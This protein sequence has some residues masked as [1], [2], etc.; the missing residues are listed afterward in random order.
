[1]RFRNHFVESI[2]RFKTK[3][4]HLFHC[5]ADKCSEMFFLVAVTP[6]SDNFASE[7]AVQPQDIP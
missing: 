5:F 2:V 4:L 7:I 6:D 3:H 1:M